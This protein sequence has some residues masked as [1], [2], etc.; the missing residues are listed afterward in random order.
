[1][2]VPV[3]TSHI[4]A[5][6]IWGRQFVPDDKHGYTNL[7]TSSISPTVDVRIEAGAQIEAGGPSNK[8]LIDRVA[9]VTCI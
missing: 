4:Q 2:P 1:M 8:S 9:M 5:Y 3:V 7:H 6:F